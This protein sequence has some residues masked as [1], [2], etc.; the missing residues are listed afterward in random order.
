MPLT[1]SFGHV[2]AA[3]TLLIC[4]GLALHMLLSPAKQR[5]VNEALRRLLQRL[6]HGTQNAR[7][8]R[9]RKQVEKS[10]AEEAAAAIRRAKNKPEGTWDGNV[11]RPKNFQQQQ[12]QPD[13]KKD[14]GHLH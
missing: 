14:K 4:L 1:Y 6:R 12:Q 7:Q 5:R 10:A 13:G 9:R 2:L 3:L 8:W 11:Y